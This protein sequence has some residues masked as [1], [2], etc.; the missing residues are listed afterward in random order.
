MTAWLCCHT[1]WHD[2]LR[3]SSAC[4]TSRSVKLLGNKRVPSTS[5]TAMLKASTHLSQHM[6]LTKDVATTSDHQSPSARHK[7]LPYH[8]HN[9]NRR[10]RQMCSGS[11][12]SEASDLRSNWQNRPQLLLD[13]SDGS[14]FPGFA[15]F[16]LF[17][18]RH[19]TRSLGAI[20]HYLKLL[21]QHL[22]VLR[23]A[24][25][26]SCAGYLWRCLQR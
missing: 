10:S 3:T 8:V 11:V 16:H 17:C 9:T 24:N 4:W 20:W 15:C 1:T 13:C 12:S 21:L 5:Q 26:A 7:L 18:Y 23:H 22:Q 25:F 6:H 19:I 2:C 14:I